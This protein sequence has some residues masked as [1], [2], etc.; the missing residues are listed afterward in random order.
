MKDKYIEFDLHGYKTKISSPIVMSLG[1]AQYYGSLHGYKIDDSGICTI[2]KPFSYSYCGA[3]KVDIMNSNINDY[4]IDIKSTIKKQK[5]YQNVINNNHSDVDIYY[6]QYNTVNCLDVGVFGNDIVQLGP[7]DY[8]KNIMNAGSGLRKLYVVHGISANELYDTLV[9]KKT[10][11]K[12]AIR[13]LRELNKKIRG[14][15]TKFKLLMRGSSN[16]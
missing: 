11:S 1:L 13:V 9:K 15:T 6:T 5:T 3:E 12:F 7:I 4:H 2:F 10:I 8:V 16:E 14:D